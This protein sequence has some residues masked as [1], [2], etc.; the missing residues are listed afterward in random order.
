MRGLALAAVI[1]VALAR[2]AAA[3]PA[4]DTKAEAEKRFQHAE[5]LYKGGDYLAAAGEYQAAYELSK[6]PGL[7]YNVAQSY[8][9]GGEKQKAV[10]AY[11]LFLERAPDHQLAAVARGHL[12]ALER[13]LAAA[14][15]AQP[16]PAEPAEPAP[17]TQSELTAAAPAAAPA[18][19]R[20]LRIAGLVTAGAGLVALGAALHYGIEARKASDAISDNDEG[21]TDSLLD[22]YDE[23]EA[24]ETRMFVL[25]GVGAA[26]LVTGGVL[27]YLGRRAGQ[28]EASVTVGALPAAGGAAAVVRGAF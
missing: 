11:R 7:L 9:L 24:A 10:D 8:R 13:E 12:E 3:Q 22:R 25:S 17:G 28:A 15:T 27:Y 23:G 1:V 20:G 21:W 18:P 5:S 19:G 6:L 2:A 14:R 16:A 4:G 26:A